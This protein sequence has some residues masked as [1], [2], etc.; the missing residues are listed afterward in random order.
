MENRLLHPPCLRRLH[1]EAATSRARGGKETDDEPERHPAA[2]RP[3]RPALPAADGR[4]QV[5]RPA[6]AL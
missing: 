2:L 3:S 6:A 5:A 1:L 4:S